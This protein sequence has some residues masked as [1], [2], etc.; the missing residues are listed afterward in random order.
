MKHSIIWHTCQLYW[1]NSHTTMSECWR[2]K[3][4][5]NR[6]QELRVECQ[7][8]KTL[9]VHCHCDVCGAAGWHSAGC[10]TS[11]VCLQHQGTVVTT[12]GVKICGSKFAPTVSKHCQHQHSAIHKTVQQYETPTISA[13]LISKVLLS[14]SSIT[15]NFVHIES[16]LF[17]DVSSNLP[18]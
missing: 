14:Q 4:S 17:L 16:S 11:W 5:V 9:A 7:G 8:V 15:A 6:L 18:K 12:N 2:Q 3:S 1:T 10:R 13:V